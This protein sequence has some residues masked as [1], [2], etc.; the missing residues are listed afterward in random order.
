MAGEPRDVPRDK[1]GDI[2]AIGKARDLAGEPR[3]DMAGDIFAIDKARDLAGEP[4]D[5]SRELSIEGN[6][7]GKITNSHSFSKLIASDL[8]GE[9]R[10]DS[11]ELS[12]ET[13]N[14]AGE[15]RDDTRE[16]SVANKTGKGTIS[17]SFSSLRSIDL[18]AIVLRDI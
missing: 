6:K 17:Q 1:T 2:I 12:V 10:D 9:P 4:R 14:L 7:T 16:L 15:P 8:A 18:L 11:R 5:D 13:N 3:G